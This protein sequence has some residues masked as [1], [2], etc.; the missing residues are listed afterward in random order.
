MPPQTQLPPLHRSSVPV[1]VFPSTCET[2]SGPHWATVVELEQ[3][4]WPPDDTSSQRESIGWQVPTRLSQRVEPP[5]VWLR[6]QIPWLQMSVTA[7]AFPLQASLPS[8]EHAQP[9]TPIAP[10]PFATQGSLLPSRAPSSTAPPRPPAPAAPPAPRAPAAPAAASAFPAPPSL[11]I[12][13][14]L[15][16][17]HCRQRESGEHRAAERP[18]WSHRV[19]P[20]STR[21]IVDMVPVIQQEARRRRAAAP[22]SRASSKRC[23]DLR[24]NDAVVY[25]RVRKPE[26]LARRVHTIL[27][28][29]G[30]GK[31][32]WLFFWH[33]PACDRRRPTRPETRRRL[34]IRTPSIWPSAATTRQLCKSSTPPTSLAHN[35]PC[36]TISGPNEELDWL[37]PHVTPQAPAYLK[38]MRER[39]DTILFGRVNCHGYLGYWPR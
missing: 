20:P 3:T 2:R 5:Q 1:Q 23:A 36:S 8:D 35:S 17:G 24:Y 28:R 21:M 14:A 39:A 27:R 19:P 30:R 15:P 16:A 9:R 38:K 34:T 13:S 4:F 18:P 31:S 37:A 12:S 10:V 6:V 33:W 32:H 22:R 7:C 11:P 25:G 29:C 26:P